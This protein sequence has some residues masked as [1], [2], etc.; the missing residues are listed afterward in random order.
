MSES[1]SLRTDRTG[2]VTAE[3]KRG[4]D[5]C[6]SVETVATRSISLKSDMDMVVAPCRTLDTEAKS[7]NGAPK[8]LSELS[9]LD[10][11]VNVLLAK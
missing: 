5:R 3:T 9:E 6:I 10:P 1:A 7:K 8:F 2:D 4:V 11:V